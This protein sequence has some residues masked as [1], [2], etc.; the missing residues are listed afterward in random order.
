MDFKSILMRELGGLCTLD[1][2]VKDEAEDQSI[3]SP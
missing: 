1:N 2:L 3:P